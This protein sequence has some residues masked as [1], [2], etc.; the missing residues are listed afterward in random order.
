IKKP[1]AEDILFGKLKKGV[2]DD[3]SKFIEQLIK[4][5]NGMVNFNILGL[6]KEEPKWNF[7]LNN[8]IMKSKIALNL[9]RGLPAKYYSS[10]RIATLMGNGCLTAIDE[11]VKYSHFFNKNEILIYKNSKDLIN[12]IMKI[13]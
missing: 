7:D 4:E 2:S 3:R 6:Y 5:A 12:K 1:L 8:E 13:K 9:S 10:N 11:R